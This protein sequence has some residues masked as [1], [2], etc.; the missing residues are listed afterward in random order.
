MV[1]PFGTRHIKRTALAVA[2]ADS[3]R[4]PPVT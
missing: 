2:V 3:V 1:A 4:F